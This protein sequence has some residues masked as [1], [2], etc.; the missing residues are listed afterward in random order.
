MTARELLE[1]I[2][3]AAADALDLRT[4]RHARRRA[5]SRRT[6]YV[7]SLQAA[8]SIGGRDAAEALADWIKEELGRR[9]RFPSG[10]DVRQRGAEICRE[11]GH[12]V[13]TGSWLGA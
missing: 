3:E 9:Q 5:G 13:P 11:Q 1:E 7:K 6:G 10:R 2:D 8:E 4:R 12:E